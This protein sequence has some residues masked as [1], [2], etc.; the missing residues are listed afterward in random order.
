MLGL[1]VDWAHRRPTRAAPKES[2]QASVSY[3]LTCQSATLTVAF[4]SCCRFTRSLYS[5]GALGKEG[6]EGGHV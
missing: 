2:N 5:R 3:L 6:G 4:F 1:M